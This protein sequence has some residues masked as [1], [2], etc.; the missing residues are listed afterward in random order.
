MDVQDNRNGEH[1]TEI[2]FLRRESGLAD[3]DSER[4]RVLRRFAARGRYRNTRLNARSDGLNMSYVARPN[5][6]FR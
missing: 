2:E 3:L 6:D 4:T 1:C 5:P